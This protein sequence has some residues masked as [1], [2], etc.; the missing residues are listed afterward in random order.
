MTT[1]GTHIH[2]F[3]PVS[4]YCDCGVRDDGSYVRPTS[5]RRLR[6][7]HGVIPALDE[8]RIDQ[9]IQDMKAARA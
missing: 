1:G 7:A 2:R 9:I 4:G 3:D 6:H 8:Q 5:G